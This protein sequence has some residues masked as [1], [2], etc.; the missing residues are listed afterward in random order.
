[1]TLGALVD[2]GLPLKELS[3]AL[4]DFPAGGYR[5]RAK[6]VM[7]GGLAAT[8]VDVVIQN[9]FRSPLSMR[10]I[11]R[12][13]ASSR[14]PRVVQE[15]SLA[16]FNRLAKAEGMASLMRRTL[17]RTRAPILSSLRRMVPQVARANW[18]CTRAMRRSAQ[19][20]T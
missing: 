4:K 10:R 12:L 17:V 20:S 6:S 3:R 7:R 8:K 19:T 13:I 1:M 5:L 9:G 2:A 14:L 15:Q 11:H 18:V 16:V